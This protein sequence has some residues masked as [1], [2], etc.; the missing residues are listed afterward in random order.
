MLDIPAISPP[1][2]VPFVAASATFPLTLFL[3]QALQH[4]FSI[5]TSDR[6][7]PL[8]LPRSIISGS[9]WTP[10]KLL[11]RPNCTAIG[12]ASVC[13]AT[14]TASTTYD[15]MCFS[16]PS[17]HRP[18]ARPS[19]ASQAG[20]HLLRTTFLGV[21]IFSMLGGR[22]YAVSPSSLISRGAY[23]RR[24]IPASAEY[25]TAGERTVLRGIFKRHGCHTCGYRPGILPS[26][27][28]FHA[29]HVPPLSVVKYLNGRGW[30]GLTGAKVKQVRDCVCVC[31]W[32]CAR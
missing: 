22:M 23:F 30:R 8:G 24:G 16:G 14:L 9:R 20:A 15:Y 6:L 2:L 7:P 21:F 29:D 26:A 27:R 4:A 31:G 28:T 19:T 1:P 10:F 13:L 25:A 5:T 32:L 3:S 11:P 12:F 18:S 17:S